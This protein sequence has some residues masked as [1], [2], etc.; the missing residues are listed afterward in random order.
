VNLAHLFCLS[1]ILTCGVGLRTPNL[2]KIRLPLALI[3]SL[4]RGSHLL[5]SLFLSLTLAYMHQDHP[6]ER[7]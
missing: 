6:D 5:G 4:T 2:L 1:L 7:G 3:P